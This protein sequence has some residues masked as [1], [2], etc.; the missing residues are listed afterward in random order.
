MEVEELARLAR[1]WKFRPAIALLDGT[2]ILWT[3]E[4]KPADFRSMMLRRLLRMLDTLRAL[5]VPLAG[6]ISSPGSTDVIN[7]LRVGL[8]PYQF[9]NC[10]K[11]EW[12]AEGKHPP[13]RGH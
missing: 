5:K 8:C 4:G 9:A 2:L 3:L 10:D 1:S 6:Y 12:I 13:L 7:A 11:C